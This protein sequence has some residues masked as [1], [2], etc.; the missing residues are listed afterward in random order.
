MIHLIIFMNFLTK[1]EKCY[2]RNTG[3]ILEIITRS[4][5]IIESNKLRIKNK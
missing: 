4:I 5:E 3:N 2:L 1:L